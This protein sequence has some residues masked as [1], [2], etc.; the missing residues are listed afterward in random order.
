VRELTDDARGPGSL[1]GFPRG[2][3]IFVGYRSLDDRSC[4]DQEAGV[5]VTRCIDPFRLQSSVAAKL[6][7][8]N[9]YAIILPDQ[10]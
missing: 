8:S 7:L 6:L 5:D 4:R 1:K 9:R 2:R 3:G 10:G